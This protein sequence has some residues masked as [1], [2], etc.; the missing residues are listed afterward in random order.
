MKKKIQESRCWQK[1]YMHFAVMKSFFLFIRDIW[2]FISVMPKESKKR[3]HI[4]PQYR[5]RFCNAGELDQHYFLQDMYIA[6]KIC[7]NETNTHYD[8]GSRVDGFIAHLL[9]SG[10]IKKVVMLDI[11]PLKYNIPGLDFVCTDATNLEGILD[12]SIDSLSS[13]HA[14]E[15]FGLGRYGDVV[16][17]DACYNAMHAMER[18]LRKNGRLYLSVPIS[19]EDSIYFNAHRVFSPKTIIT[20]FKQLTLEEFTYISDFS[21]CSYRGQE[22]VDM[23][24]NGKLPLGDYDCGMFIFRKE[25]I[26]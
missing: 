2:V 21:L 8:I 7:S 13:L 17:P 24:M 9:A 1:M 14:V 12:E 4:L 22:A 18:V 6:Q 23:I 16:D 10:R 19:N 3:L 26:E 11:R 15:H 20:N 25:Y 5:D